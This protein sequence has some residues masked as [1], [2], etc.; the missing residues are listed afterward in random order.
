MRWRGW[1]FGGAALLAAACLDGPTPAEVT[2][3]L[4]TPN[5]DDGAISFTITSSAPNEVTG[6]TATCDSCAAF[7][8]RVSATELRGIITGNLAAGPVARVGVMNGSPN[9]AYSVELREIASRALAPR[10]LSG[11]T[12]AVQP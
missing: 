2:L 1:I 7:V 4:T 6:V 8:A 12:L 11:Y 3:V 9:Q 5:Q 10:G